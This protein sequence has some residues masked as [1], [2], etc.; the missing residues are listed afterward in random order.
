MGFETL[1]GVPGC[2]IGVPARKLRTDSQSRWQRVGVIAVLSEGSATMLRLLLLA[3]TAAA[4][5]APQGI[6][7]A[8]PRCTQKRAQPPQMAVGLL[9][10]VAARG[11]LR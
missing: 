2:M 1:V 8:R 11:T 6:N 4:L 3:A 10:G 9:R 7:A 5:V